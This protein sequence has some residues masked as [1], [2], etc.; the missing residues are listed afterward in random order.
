MQGDG[1][2]QRVEIVTLNVLD[3]SHGHGG[4]V[5]DLFYHHRH[6][7]QTGQLCCTPATLTGDNLVHAVF[8]GTHHDRLYH[9]LRGDGIGQ[10]AQLVF[11]EMPARLVTQR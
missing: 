9:A 5:V 8:D 7:G 10:F 3:Q 4:L 2:F 6:I 11:I 1:L